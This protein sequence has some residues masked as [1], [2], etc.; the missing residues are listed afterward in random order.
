MPVEPVRNT[1]G[2]SE[3]SDEFINRFLGYLTLLLKRENDYV[4]STAACTSRARRICWVCT[5]T[6]LRYDMLP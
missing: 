2:D 6:V 3:L 5:V 4:S 1:G